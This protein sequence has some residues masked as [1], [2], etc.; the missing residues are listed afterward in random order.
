MPKI[1]RNTLEGWD[2]LVI[3]DD[4]GSLL[5]ANKMLM[6]YGAT[7]HQ[8]WNGA[9]GLKMAREMRPKL[10]ISDLSMPVMDGWD[11]VRYLKEDPETANITTIALTAH[12]MSGDRDRAIAAGFNEYL[13]KPLIPGT[14]MLDLL[15]RL[16]TISQNSAKSQ[17]DPKE[18]KQ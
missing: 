2:I 18:S 14:F 9:E 3:D 7:V 8:A 15:A 12:A 4:P 17:A 16:T 11:L 5:V 10:I 6:H 1:A 13:S